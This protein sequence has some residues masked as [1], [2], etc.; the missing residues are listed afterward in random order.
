MRRAKPV[1]L[2]TS[3][4]FRL[5]SHRMMLKLPTLVAAPPPSVVRS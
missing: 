5:L 3:E 4:L 1:W 2:S